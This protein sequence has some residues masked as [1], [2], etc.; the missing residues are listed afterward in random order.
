MRCAPSYGPKGQLSPCPKAEL[1]PTARGGGEGRLKACRI[2]HEGVPTPL[3]PLPRGCNEER[4]RA[5][6]EGRKE[7]KA[8][9]GGGTDNPTPRLGKHLQACLS[10]MPSP[11]LNRCGEKREEGADAT[12]LP[13]VAYGP[14]AW[15]LCR[16]LTPEPVG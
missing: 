7:G 12:P 16:I 1:S 15:L 2:R 13:L 5:V 4:K 3:A 9:E 11:M 8:V 6:A 10:L 14:A